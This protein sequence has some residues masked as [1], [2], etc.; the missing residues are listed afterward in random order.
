MDRID[1]ALVKLAD[2]EAWSLG[3][4]Y[5]VRGDIHAMIGNMAHARADYDNNG[6]ININDSRACALI[7]TLKNC[8]RPPQ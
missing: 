8:A 2:E 4:G 6:I 5:R 1:A 3:E 7:C